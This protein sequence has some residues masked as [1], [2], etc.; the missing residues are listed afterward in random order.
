MVYK[1]KIVYHTVL[2]GINMLLVTP[3][4][5]GSMLQVHWNIFGE[6]VNSVMDTVNSPNSS[7]LCT[8]Y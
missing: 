6:A 4:E 1:S 8:S 7:A 5:Y 3:W 2:C